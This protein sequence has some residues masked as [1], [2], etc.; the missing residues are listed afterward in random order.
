[1][2]RL[3]TRVHQQ[4]LDNSGGVFRTISWEALMKLRANHDCSRRQRVFCS[5]AHKTIK[6][7]VPAADAWVHVGYSV[8]NGE[9]HP[10]ESGQWLCVR[11]RL[12]L[13]ER[14]TCLNYV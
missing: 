2:H 3:L 12:T 1:L 7:L 9:R 6:N 10:A 14:T 5:P 8:Q 11:Y 13:S 4:I